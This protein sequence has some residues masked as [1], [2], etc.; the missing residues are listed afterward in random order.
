MD[1]ILYKFVVPHQ[2]DLV[3][4]VKFEDAS[5]NHESCSKEFSN[6]LYV[7]LGTLESFFHF[8]QFLHSH[9]VS[10]VWLT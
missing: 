8:L 3:D 5:S 6:S 1:P 9:K 10:Q 2:F 4:I 7:T